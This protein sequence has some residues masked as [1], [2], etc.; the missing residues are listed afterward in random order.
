MAAHAA[1]S[2]QSFESS[3]SDSS[4]LLTQMAQRQTQLKD[5]GEVVRA[6]G[7]GHKRKQEHASTSG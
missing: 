6:D 4:Y 7:I 5:G 3:E 2:P 1:G